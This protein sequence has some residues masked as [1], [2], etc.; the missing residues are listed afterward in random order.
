MDVVAGVAVDTGVEVA[1]GGTSVA[2]DTGLGVRVLGLFKSAPLIANGA[3][4]LSGT[5]AT[6]SARAGLEPG[7][8]SAA[9]T[10]RSPTGR[11]NNDARRERD[12]LQGGVAEGWNDCIGTLLSGSGCTLHSIGVRRAGVGSSQQALRGNGDHACLQ[13]GCHGSGEPQGWAVVGLS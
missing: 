4:A 2:V 6:I 3:W 11:A 1:A 12:D 9:S 13:P 5:D 7:A 10:S 8:T